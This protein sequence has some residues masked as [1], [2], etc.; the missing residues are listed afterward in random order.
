M[1]FSLVPCSER[2]QIRELI[3]YGGGVLVQPGKLPDAIR[4][5]PSSVT[6]TDSTDDAFS[7]NY[8][9]ACSKS[10]KL[11]RLIDFKIPTAPAVVDAS[12]HKT[13]TLRFVRTR[14]EYTLGEEIA[15]AK[16]VARKPGVCVR[17]N[18]VYKEMA[19]T[20]VVPGKHSWQSLKEHYLKKIFPLKRLYESPNAVNVLSRTQHGEAAGVPDSSPLLSEASDILVED[21]SGEQDSREPQMPSGSGLQ[22]EKTPTDVVPETECSSPPQSSG[23]SVVS[24]RIY[25][26]KG[27]RKISF[28]AS[29]T[30]ENPEKTLRESSNSA[31]ESPLPDKKDDSDHSTSTS[32]QGSSAIKLRKRTPPTPPDVLRKKQKEPSTSSVS[33]HAGSRR[34]LRKA[35]TGK[36]DAPDTAGQGPILN[37]QRELRS[38]L[39]QCKNITPQKLPTARRSTKSGSQ[40]PSIGRPAYTAVSEDRSVSDVID[41]QQT[42]VKLQPQTPVNPNSAT[43]QKCSSN[44]LGKQSLH[45]SSDSNILENVVKHTSPTRF[46]RMPLR[47]SPRKRPNT[48]PQELTN[49]HSDSQPYSKS[50][51]DIGVTAKKKRNSCSPGRCH[52]SDSGAAAGLLECIPPL[53]RQGVTRSSPRKRQ[54]AGL[55]KDSSSHSSTRQCCKST[56]DAIPETDPEDPLAPFHAGRS[57]LSCALPADRHMKKD[58]S[59]HGEQAPAS[60]SSDKYKCTDPSRKSNTSLYKQHKTRE[61]HEDVSHRNM[62]PSSTP[63]YD[64]ASSSKCTRSQSSLRKPQH[65][66]GLRAPAAKSARGRKKAPQSTLTCQISSKSPP[67]LQYSEGGHAGSACQAAGIGKDSKP[68]LVIGVEVEDL[69]SADEA[70][71][72]EALVQEAALRGSSPTPHVAEDHPVVP[73]KEEHRDDVSEAGSLTSTVSIRSTVTI[74]D[75]S[76]SAD[77]DSAPE[78]E[79]DEVAKVRTG[80]VR[81]LRILRTGKN[82]EPH[83]RCPADCG[84]SR[85]TRYIRTARAAVSCSAFLAFHGGRLPSESPG[86]KDPEMALLLEVLL[87]HLEASDENERDSSSSA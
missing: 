40:R 31:V 70:L 41:K 85:S 48:A 51:G 30:A 21:S 9:R 72:T 60:L 17:G 4:L 23:T 62:G 68:L 32:D 69:D 76:H 87:R 7:V 74:S 6:V 38:S 84:C 29:L 82:T 49:S 61:G 18:A 34:G 28:S 24:A 75:F 44:H 37:E 3:E 42:P 15:I 45:Q 36:V 81:L 83:E 86:I 33:V 80:L 71:L 20:S 12:D 64:T 47:T 8:I 43:R 78:S 2:K 59:L 11:L 58:I 14:R 54:I 1:L 73:I 63:S 77:E 25:K 46:R 55:Q 35:N 19:S 53:S 66:R 26:R 39:R 57:L 16:Y 52:D 67:S 13:Q 22:D 50:S 65:E 56:N 79:Q 27:V 5:A 10:D